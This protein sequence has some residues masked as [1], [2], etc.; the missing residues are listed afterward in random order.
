MIHLVQ[1]RRPIALCA[2]GAPN[3]IHDTVSHGQVGMPARF[4]GGLRNQKAIGAENVAFAFY[5]QRLGAI[6]RPRRR[7]RL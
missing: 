1:K 3:K 2:S 7:Q 5:R 4:T 6:F